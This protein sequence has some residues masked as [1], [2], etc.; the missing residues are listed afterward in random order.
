[1]A[2]VESHKNLPDHPAFR[3]K[4]PGHLTFEKIL[5]LLA[6]VTLIEVLISTAHTDGLF[7][8]QATL[9]VTAILLIFF[10]FFKASLVAGYFMHL[11]YEKRPFV[12]FMLAF[13]FPFLIVVPVAIM[14]ITL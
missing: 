6:V 10:S 9:A 11:F 12:I 2:H 1:M 14:V 4:H 7:G 5:G 3:T 8:F 13:G